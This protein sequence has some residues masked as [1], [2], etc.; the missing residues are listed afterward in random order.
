MQ[1]IASI[2]HLPLPKEDTASKSVSCVQEMIWLDFQRIC[3]P[4][5]LGIKIYE[6]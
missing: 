6:G 1:K 5:K 2:R 4:L 3:S